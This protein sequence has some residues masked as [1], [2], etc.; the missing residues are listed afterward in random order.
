MS[1]EPQ[2]GDAGATDPAKTSYA[3]IVMGD[4]RTS[5]EKEGDT[6]TFANNEAFAEQ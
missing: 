3:H 5:T 6:G 4:A 1:F 2:G